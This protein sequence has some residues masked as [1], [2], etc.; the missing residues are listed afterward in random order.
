MCC[1]GC[2]IHRRPSAGGSSGGSSGP[3]RAARA[4][5]Q[6]QHA[7]SGLSMTVRTA[8]SLAV[9]A[10]TATQRAAPT[11]ARVLP[12]EH[13]FS[14]RC[15]RA[16]PVV[17]RHAKL[18]APHGALGAARYMTAWRPQQTSERRARAAARG[19]TAL[20]SMTY[21]L[22]SL[23]MRFSAMKPDH[24]TAT[25]LASAR[26]ARQQA[27]ANGQGRRAGATGRGAGGG[28]GTTSDVWRRE[29]RPTTRAASTPDEC[30]SQQARGKDPGQVPFVAVFL[31]TSQRR[32]LHKLAG[33]GARCVLDS[34]RRRCCC[35]CCGHDCDAI[36]LPHVR[37][38]AWVQTVLPVVVFF[39]K[40][41]PGKIITI[42]SGN[43]VEEFG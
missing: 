13:I 34:T 22:F 17:R 20:T 1:R 36:A 14:L 15:V 37:G 4:H 21:V 9:R 40:G 38:S 26:Q 25:H 2:G 3:A 12:D 41:K 39:C 28:V 18:H 19:P 29:R 16:L 11:I 30:A 5:R 23:R 24:P 27:R 32:S 43:F 7:R 6:P 35:Y 42:L 10:P 8:A 33:A 31:A